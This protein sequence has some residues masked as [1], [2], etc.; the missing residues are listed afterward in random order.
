MTLETLLN[1]LIKIY[2]PAYN[3]RIELQQAIISPRED[4]KYLV[5]VSNIKALKEWCFRIER[6]EY[7]MEEKYILDNIKLPDA[8]TK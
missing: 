8:D 6:I 5:E 1:R 7:I 2:I 3:G 4:W